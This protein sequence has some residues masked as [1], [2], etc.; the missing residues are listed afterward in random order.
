[1]NI[2]QVV[3]KPQRRGAET[4]ALQLSWELKC[5][6]HKVRT[7]YLYGHEGENALPLTDDD[8]VLGGREHHCFEKV[9]GVHPA[10]LWRLR[11][12]IEETQ[13]D[14]VQVNGGRTVKYGAAIAAQSKKRPWVLIYRCIGQPRYWRNG[15]RHAFYSRLV[16]P[17]LDGVISVSGSTLEAVEQLYE[18]SVPA[19]CIPCAVDPKVVAPTIDRDVIRQRTGTPLDAPVVVC[20]GS[21]SQEKRLDRLLR[22]AAA[23]KERIPALHVWIVGDGPLRHALASEVRTSSLAHC[24][25]FLGVQNQV[26]NYMNAAD[27]VALTSDSEGMPAVLLEAGLLGLPVVATRVGGVAECVLDGETGVLVEPGDDQSLSDAL[28]SLLQQPERLHR[29]GTTA[30]TWIERTFTINRVAK[31]YSSFYERVLAE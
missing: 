7:V 13:P 15:L 1:M 8:T 12:V 2:L 27:L 26:A 17:R 23:V 29:L 4:F 14:V 22:A 24:V 28:G 21:L 19:V 10:L 31:Q 3:Q 18:L 25:R 5:A 30:K 9:P 20:V 11:R 16:L 6:G